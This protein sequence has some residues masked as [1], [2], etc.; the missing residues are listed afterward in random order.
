MS[1]ETK[2]EQWAIVDVMGH[3]RFV[4]LVTEQVV[5]G[6]G[7]VRVDIPETSTVKAW[8]KLIGTSSIYAITPVDEGIAK[9]MAENQTAKPIQPY[10][11]TANEVASASQPA[12]PGQFDDDDRPW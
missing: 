11:L 7:F 1:E 10:E 4:G 12:L 6:Q 9:S 3:Q 8:T 2:F 5:A